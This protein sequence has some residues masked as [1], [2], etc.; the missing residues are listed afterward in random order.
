MRSL[1]IYIVAALA[2][3]ATVFSFAPYRLYWVMPLTL[4][5]LGQLLQQKQSKPFLTGYIWGIAA[6]AANFSWIYISLHDIAGMPAW[7]AGPLVLLLPVYLAIYPGLASW[8][9]IRISPHPLIR[10]LILFPSTWEIGEWLR[11]WMLTGFPW[12]AAGYSQITE[13]PLS[14]Y[15]PVGGIHL[16]TTLVALT[17]G[18]MLAIL[19]VRKKRYKFILLSSLL[20][21][22]G[23][24]YWLKSIQWTEPVGKPFSVALAQGN[25][26]QGIKWDPATYEMTL[27]TYYHEIATTKADLMILPETALPVFLEDLPTGYLSMLRG[28]AARN[29]M[30]VI[31]GILKRT[32][33]NRGYL[34]AAV[35]LTETNMPFY[36]KDHLVPFGEFIPLPGLLSWIYQFMNMPLSGFSRGGQQQMPIAVNGQKIAFNI[37]YEDSFGEELIHSAKQATIL[38][39]I[40]NLAWFGRSNAI[41]QHLQLSQTRALEMGRYMVRASNTGMTAI[42]LPDGEIASAAAPFT[43][44]TLEGLVQGRQGMTPY[45][46]YGN[47]PVL[48]VIFLAFITVALY[49]VIQRKQQTSPSKPA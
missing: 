24:G 9:T 15:A 18:I 6:Y 33:D 35:A 46:R 26:P 30:A 31:S 4:C 41:S 19:H 12:G 13:S 36:A 27:R 42:I 3:A 23:N 47:T 20:L 25:I 40:S 5:I 37:C 29:H 39:N 16:V 14:G 8:L 38:A 21:L 7:L 17:S 1:L 49:H 11:S 48:L 44:Q 45:M 2:G 32:A 10:W 28:D 22:W 43:Q 34:N